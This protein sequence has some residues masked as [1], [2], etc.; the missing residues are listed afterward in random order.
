MPE[1][2]LETIDRFYGK[3]PYPILYCDAPVNILTNNDDIPKENF[4]L[5]NGVP[6]SLTTFV[7]YRYLAQ[8]HLKTNIAFDVQTNTVY[9]LVLP[10][11]TMIVIIMP[12]NFIRTGLKTGYFKFENNLIVRV[13]SSYMLSSANY[14]PKDTYEISVYNNSN[15][16][17]RS[18]IEQLF[19]RFN[20]HKIVMKRPNQIYAYD[21]YMTMVVG[22]ISNIILPV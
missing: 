10:E 22:S 4:Y 6:S 3:E 13:Y 17:V 8:R 15:V 14:I 21:K 11:K 1:T 19:A 7:E 9:R 2:Y 16:R 12:E 5:S 18:A 20:L